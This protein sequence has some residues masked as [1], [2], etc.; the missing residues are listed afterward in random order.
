[1]RVWGFLTGLMLLAVIPAWAQSGHDSGK[2]PWLPGT[3]TVSELGKDISSVRVIDLRPEEAFAEYHIPGSIN[4]PAETVMSKNW[5]DADTTPLVLVDGDG[6]RAMAVAT[7]VKQTSMRPVSIL[8]GGVGKYWTKAAFKKA[9]GPRDSVK[10]SMPPSPLP[11]GNEGMKIPDVSAPI[12]PMSPGTSSPTSPE[13]PKP[14][15]TYDMGC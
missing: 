12:A 6:Y 3:V 8:A 13:P 4:I 5:L 1:M 2:E 7:L 9:G 14:P 10:T 11:Q 15:K